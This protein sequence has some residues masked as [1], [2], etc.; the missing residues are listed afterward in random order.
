[1]LDC[2]RPLIYMIEGVV[3]DIMHDIPFDVCYRREARESVRARMDAKA[4][5][6]QGL[7][8]L[9]RAAQNLSR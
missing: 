7:L 3:E 2:P 8:D 9:A 5:D 1:V 6:I 4:T